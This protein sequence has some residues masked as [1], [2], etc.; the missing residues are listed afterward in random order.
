MRTREQIHPFV[1]PVLRKRLALYAAKRGLTQ[2]AVV[3]TALLEHLDGEVTD[4]ALVMRRLDRLGRSLSGAQRDVEC[5]GEAFAA[6]IRTWFAH[7]PRLA[8]DQRGPAEKAARL[9]YEQFLDYVAGQVAAGRSFTRTV[10][11]KAT[12]EEDET[13]VGGA[14]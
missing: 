2:S 13:D 1:T 7:T 11:A 10:A 8:E 4:R 9:R 3:E 6:F 14:P 5:L 12:P